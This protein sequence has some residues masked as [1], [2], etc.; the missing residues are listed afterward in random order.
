MVL[1]FDGDEAGQSA[2]DR[3]LEFFLASELDLRVLALPANLD[4][5]DFLLEEGADAF[6]ALAERAVDPLDYLLDSSR[7]RFD[8][9]LDR[10]LAAGRRV[11]GGYFEPRSRIPSTRISSSSKAKVLDTLSHRLRVPSR[12]AQW[13]A[14]AVAAPGGRPTPQWHAGLLSAGLESGR[15]SAGI[16][17]AQRRRPCSVQRPRS[18]RATSTPTDLELIRIILNE[19][20]AITRLD[21]AHRRLHSARRPAAG[22]P[23]GLLRPASAMGRAPSYEKLMIRIDDR[24]IRGLIVDLAGPSAA[25]YARS[26]A[27]FRDVVRPAPWQE[28]LEKMLIVLDERER[29]ARRIESEKSDR[30]DRSHTPTQRR[31]VP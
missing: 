20:T 10:G 22:D 4:P 2:A 24:A 18:G 16:D 1:V 26:S 27:L 14:P 7:G 17:P 23:A 11:G 21:P 29:T 19:P 5:C 8:L 31:I 25:E 12:H 3:A 13:L 15:R 28:R 6:R 30:R 9:E